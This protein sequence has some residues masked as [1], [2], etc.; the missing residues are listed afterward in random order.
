MQ[1]TDDPG[2]R[3]PRTFRLHPKTAAAIDRIARAKDV[4]KTT[5]VDLALSHALAQIEAGALRIEKV[6]A[7]Y[8]VIALTP[9]VNDSAT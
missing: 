5:L 9:G 6:P 7:S 1:L 3:I 2:Y 4:S 8:R